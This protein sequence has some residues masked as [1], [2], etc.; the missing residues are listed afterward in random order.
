VKNNSP[1]TSGREPF[2]VAKFNGLL[3]TE[4]FGRRLAFEPSVGSTMDVARV[5]ALDGAP[6]GAVSLADEQT[7][8]RGRM[9]R[10]W[11]TPP[12]VN[13]VPTLVLRPPPH[14]L[15]AVAMAAPL[16]VVGA[17]AALHGIDAVIKWPNDVQADGRK[18]AGVLLEPHVQD[19][20]T[21]FVLVGT[22]INVNFDPEAHADTRDI[23]TSVAALLGRPVEREPLLSEY[24][25]AFER[26]YDDARAGGSIRDRWRERLVTLGKQVQAT[27]PGGTVEGTAEEVDD[28]G[29]LLVRTAD[30][31]LVTVEA[32][33]VTLR[34]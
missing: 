25:A 17:V 23:A 29:S 4:A 30:G 27:W 19:G 10:G 26:L 6:E 24:L 16:A 2:D 13:L 7:A 1:E 18:L 33:D 20:E 32:G 15:R 14:A 31:Q 9:G 12:A 21:A 34:R 5:M 3:R 28:D 11:V 8:G 22:G